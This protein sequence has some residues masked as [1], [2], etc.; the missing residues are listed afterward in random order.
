M[1]EYVLYGIFKTSLI[2]TEPQA[3]YCYLKPHHW[4]LFIADSSCEIFY[5]SLASDMM[6]GRYNYLIIF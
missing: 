3:G 2:L 1:Q 4:S 5:S 6:I